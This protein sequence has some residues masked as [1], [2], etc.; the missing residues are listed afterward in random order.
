M[1][2][3]PSKGVSM[4]NALECLQAIQDLNIV[5]QAIHCRMLKEAARRANIF[6]YPGE[7]YP[8]RLYEARV[9]AQKIIRDLEPYKD[10]VQ[11]MH[12]VRKLQPLIDM[13]YKT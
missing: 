2:H 11:K 10:G 1:I 3:F 6:R 8:D 4:V 13:V 9:I 7:W 12:I 5:Y